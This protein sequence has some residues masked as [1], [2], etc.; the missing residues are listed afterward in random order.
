M[1]ILSPTTA[2]T[3]PPLAQDGAQTHPQPLI[4]LTQFA[5]KDVFKVS[6]P[7]SPSG[8]RAWTENEKLFRFAHSHFILADR[9]EIGPCLRL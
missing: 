7:A 8:P 6:A 9:S 3:A 1:V 5:G 2:P 4:D